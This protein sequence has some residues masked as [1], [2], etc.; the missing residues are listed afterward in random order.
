M[1]RASMVSRSSSVPAGSGRWV[2]ARWR[3]GWCA[4]W[5]ALDAARELFRAAH[6]ARGTRPFGGARAP[7]ARRPRAGRRGRAKR[8]RGRHP[9][10]LGHPIDP[11]SPGGG[12][13]GGSLARAGAEWLRP[14]MRWPKAPP[15]HLTVLR[16]TRAQS[17]GPTKASNVSAVCC[18]AERRS[19][20]EV[21]EIVALTG[22]RPDH[23]FLSEL[24]LEIG[25]ATEG[26]AR[27]E[28]A[29]AKVT[30][31][32]T[33][34]EV[35]AAD[36]IG[37]ARLPPDWRQELRSR[38]HLPARE[39]LRAART[40][41]RAALTSAAERPRDQRRDAIAAVSSWAPGGSTR[42]PF[43]PIITLSM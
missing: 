12:G 6:P 3:S 14:P 19:L 24:A 25:P 38:T 42:S 33:P 22:Y 13:G 23:R 11:H 16:R 27:L 34:P 4:I 8:R 21:H 43:D 17:L 36:R 7:C 9:D 39:R 32:L 5:G 2:S 40:G 10:H 28:R 20:I 31:C 35:S 29:V 1:R 15:P 30:D 18:P 37:R 26:G 41:A